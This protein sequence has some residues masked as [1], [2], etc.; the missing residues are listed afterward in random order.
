MPKQGYIT[1]SSFKDLM[2]KGKG[3]DSI[4][5]GAYTIVDELV[6]D[7]IGVEKG[8]LNA[9]VPYSC[10]WGI[11]HEW[12]A[13]ETY[14]EETFR[15]VL[16]PVEFRVAQSNPYVGGTMDGLVGSKGGVEIKSPFNPLNHFQNLQDGKQL[17]TLYWYQVQGYLWIYEL[18]W[19]DFV[20]YDPRF[21][22]DKQLYIERV[23]P[24][25]ETIQKLK[26]RCEW[27]YNLA[28]EKIRSIA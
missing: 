19:I 16:H 17:H 9:S 7:M 25:N 2:A 21:P 5:Q 14:Q 28:T 15:E 10:Q 24:D 20:S 3:K 27:A 1:A 23:T 6:L 13:I 4:G 11:D 8:E 18:D 22:K 12:S 26:E